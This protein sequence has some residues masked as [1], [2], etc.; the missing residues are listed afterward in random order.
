MT[1]N[2][3]QS[4]LKQIIIMVIMIKK[5]I[6]VSNITEKDTYSLWEI[7]F[8][9]LYAIQPVVFCYNSPNRQ[10][11]SSNNQ[12]ISYNLVSLYLLDFLTTCW[13]H[14]LFPCSRQNGTRSFKPIFL[15]LQA[16]RKGPFPGEFIQGL[17]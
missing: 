17:R 3:T 10:T 6:N 14:Y 5:R 11:I 4:G 13:L 1:E 8:C 9:C 2:S 12:M 16:E 7:N 15:L